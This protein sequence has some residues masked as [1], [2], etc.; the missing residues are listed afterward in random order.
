M[1]RP[2][3]IVVSDM[4]PYFLDLDAPTLPA[5]ERACDDGRMLWGSGA[6]TA[7]H[8]IGMGRTRDIESATARTHQARTT[9]EDTTWRTPGSGRTG[10]DRCPF[11][12][13]SMP[14]SP[15]FDVDSIQG[16]R[17]RPPLDPGRLS[18]LCCPPD[19]PSYPPL[20]ARGDMRKPYN[21]PT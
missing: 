14:K 3:K 12:N 7:T 17:S 10:V 6:S 16:A 9:R 1:A 19:Q 20:S 5:Y 15:T 2:M 18:P 4:P 13:A 21:T 11:L 8:G